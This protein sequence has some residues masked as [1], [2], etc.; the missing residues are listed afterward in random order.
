M[1][2]DA[3]KERA[4][5]AARLQ[6]ERL[7]HDA[8]AAGVAV[9]LRKTSDAKPDWRTATPSGLDPDHYEHQR[10]ERRRHEPPNPAH[11][12]IFADVLGLEPEVA[13]CLACFRKAA[14]EAPRQ[15]RGPAGFRRL[16]LSSFDPFDVLEISRPAP[17]IEAHGP[18]RYVRPPPEPT[19]AER[20]EASRRMQRAVE[21]LIGMDLMRADDRGF[22]WIYMGVRDA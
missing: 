15:Y 19:A 2:R 8:D 5:A 14:Q 9:G 11:L 17:E 10:L 13:Y 6:R 3:Q 22:H 4:V 16:V 21:V 20:L 7:R 18:I 12:A 1:T